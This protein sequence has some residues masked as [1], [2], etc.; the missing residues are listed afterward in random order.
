MAADIQQIITLFVFFLAVTLCMWRWPQGDRWHVRLCVVAAVLWCGL[1][2]FEPRT[3]TWM[4]GL[5]VINFLLI[6]LSRPYRLRVESH[7]ARRD[8]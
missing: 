2:V 5:I 7:D 1:L 6:G 3:R 4:Y 8:A